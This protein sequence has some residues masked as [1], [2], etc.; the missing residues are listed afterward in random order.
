MYWDNFKMGCRINSFEIITLLFKRFGE[1][2]FKYFKEAAKNW[3]IWH[4]A[5]AI[6]TD[7]LD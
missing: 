1:L 3:A 4:F 2:I 5:T 6:F 7:Q